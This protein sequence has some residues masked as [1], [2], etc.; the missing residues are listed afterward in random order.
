VTLLGVVLSQRKIHMASDYSSKSAEESLPGFTV[1][2]TS[3]TSVV[4]PVF[5]Y[6]L[7]IFLSAFLLFQV[8]PIIARYILPWFGGTPATWTTCMLFFQ[9]FLLGGYA[10]AHFLANMFSIR[11]QVFIH[12]L[13]LVCSL[14]F[15]PIIP[16]EHWKFQG[17]EDPMLRIVALLSVTIGGPF[18]LISASG[19]LLQYWFSK[20]HPTRSPYRLYALSNLGSLLGLLSYP[21][22]IEPHLGLKTQTWFWSWGYGIYAA[23]CA[24]AAIPLLQTSTQPGTP[25]RIQAS[26][27]DKPKFS[28][29]LLTL[30]LP[31]CGSVLLLASTNQI[32]RDVAV[33]PFL[34]VLPLSLYLGSFIVCFDHARWYDRRVWVPVL[35][36]SVA[37]VVYLLHQDYGENEI[38]VYVQ[39][40]IYS[41]AL[42]ACCMICHG[43]LVR[44]KP[45]PRYLTSFYL[46]IALGGALGSIMVNVGAPLLFKGYWE[47]HAGLIAT[48]LLLGICIFRKTEGVIFLLPVWAGRLL[49]MGS[50]GVLTTFLWWHIQEQQYTSILTKRNFYGV[51]RVYESDSGTSDAVRALYHGRISHGEQ[52]LDSTRRTIPRTYYGPHSG[53]SLAVQ[54]HPRQVGRDPQGVDTV[55]PGLHVGIV[56][57]GVGTIAAYSRPGDQYRFYEIDPHVDVISQEYFT[58]RQDAQGKIQIILGD[59]RISLERELGNNDPQLFD[60]LALDAFTSDAVPV[61]LLTKEAFTLYWKHLRPDGVLAVNI[62]NHHVDLSPVVRVLAREVGKQAIWIEDYGEEEE[63]EVSEEERRTYPN[64]W[65]LVTSNQE[66]LEDEE[67]K[68]H[69]SPWPSEVPRE[70]LWTDDYSNLFKVIKP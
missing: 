35:M 32:C 14:L 4:F 64:D 70:I 44:L 13:L 63:E 47:F 57:L 31:A 42:F 41:A 67:I 15:L 38:H 46:M 69:I 62:S 7:A 22:V 9:V 19:P 43:E 23:M 49:W 61:H 54:R 1:P 58:Y 52:F 29:R 5:P 36:I 51:L 33:I 53:I 8:E 40:G 11:G 30:L 28:D 56:G 10:Y 37:S 24:W 68:T 25:A 34:W 48:V 65:V 39:I 45:P 27:D 55:P 21:F 59:G 3:P 50:L 66:F 2:E 60:V 12:V 6:V 17:P 18:L 26:E 16:Q 20:A